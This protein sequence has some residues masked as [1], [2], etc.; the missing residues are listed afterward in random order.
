MHDTNTYFTFSMR[1]N[2]AEYE[3]YYRGTAQNIRIMTH[4]GVS[5]Q[6]PASAVRPFLQ[7]DGVN[8]DFV[9]FMDSNNKLVSLR[10]LED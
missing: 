6:F 1:L 2:S 9:I 8:G 3:R 5:I 10:K 7:S 4:Q